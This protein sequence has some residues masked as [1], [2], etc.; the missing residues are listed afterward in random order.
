MSLAKFYWKPYFWHRAYYVGSVG[1]ASL[2]TVKRYEAHGTKDGHQEAAT[3]LTPSP[4]R[5]G[6]GNARALCSIQD[7]QPEECDR[8]VAHAVRDIRTRQHGVPLA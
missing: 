6:K 2:D 8:E 7:A 5:P 1:G 4:L 3:R